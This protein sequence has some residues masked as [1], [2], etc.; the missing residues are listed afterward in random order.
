M[1]HSARIHRAV[2]SFLVAAA[3]IVPA[4][5]GSASSASAAKSTAPPELTLVA[6]TP[7]VTLDTTEIGT[8]KLPPSLDLGT[9]VADSGGPF[10]L[11]AT[12]R[13]YTSAIAVGEVA[14]GR[15]TPLRKGLVTGLAGLSDFFHVTIV[16]SAGATVL[17]RDETF[18]PNAGAAQSAPGAPEASQFPDSCATNPFA[19]DATWGITPGWAASTTAADTAPATGGQPGAA[20]KPDLRSLPAWGIAVAHT[21]SGDYLDFS[22]TV[23]NA[24]PGPL[25]V[26]GFREPGTDVMDAYQY[27][28]DVQG[29]EVGHQKVGTVVWDPDPGHQHWHFADFARYSL[30]NADQTTAVLSQKDGFC[31]ANTDAVDTP[32]PDTTL[33]P[34]NTDLHSSCGGISALSVREAL[35]TGWGDTYVQTL[36]GQ[37]FDITDLPNGTYY[38]QIAANPDGTLAESVP[39]DPAAAPLREVVLGGTAGNRTVAVPPVGVVSG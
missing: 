8:T 30:L 13:S 19:L 33:S 16:D 26:Q 5:V 15:T 9:F 18:C 6:E 10:E 38:V 17:T 14:A 12:R 31:L 27:F 24:G 20:L 23:W 35:A 32:V 21:S 22:A 4:E 11:R 1:I 34:S 37:S 29:G 2:A 7:S 3:L 25:V 39:D 36:P 28:D